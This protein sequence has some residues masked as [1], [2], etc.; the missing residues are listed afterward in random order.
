MA[1][2]SARAK[3]SEGGVVRSVPVQTAVDETAPTA[4]EQRM[5]DFAEDLGTILGSAEKKA[6][7]WLSQ[8]ESVGEQLKRIRDTAND[9]LSRLTGTG[10]NVAAA[11]ARGRRRGQPP[12]LRSTAPQTK[13]AKRGPGRPKGSGRRKGGISAEG[14]ARIAAAQ[15]ARWAKIKG[16]SR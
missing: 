15:K 3:K 12:G 10:A 8:R 16:E 4:V 11:V 14:R 9:L 6:S 7:E 13:Q 2:R 1:K 5:V